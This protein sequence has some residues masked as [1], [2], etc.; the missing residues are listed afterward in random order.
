MI[1]CAPLLGFWLLRF[2]SGGWLGASAWA[3]L[4]VV[5]PVIAEEYREFPSEI[6]C[7]PKNQ[8]FPRSNPASRGKL[9]ETPP[10]GHLGF[11]LQWM[12]IKQALLRRWLAGRHCLDLVHVA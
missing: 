2:G 8:P 12:P 11:A 6:L 1:S 7:S 5:G 9:Q 4:L 10:S 3:F